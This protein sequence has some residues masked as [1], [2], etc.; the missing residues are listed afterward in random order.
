MT[1]FLDANALCEIIVPIVNDV[2]AGK[3]P[4]STTTYNNGVKDVPASTYDPYLIDKDNVQYL[5][6]VGFYTDAEV[7]G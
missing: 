7:N 3:E 6:D 5:V 4:A 1:A 2:F